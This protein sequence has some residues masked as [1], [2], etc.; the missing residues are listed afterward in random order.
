MT[1]LVA[2]IIKQTRVPTEMQLQS[3]V[4]ITVLVLTFVFCVYAVSPIV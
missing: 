2:K 3:A 1:E 4:E